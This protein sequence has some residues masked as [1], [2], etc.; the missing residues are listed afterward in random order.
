[1]TQDERWMANWKE[2][3]DFLRPCEDSSFLNIPSFVV[4][5]FL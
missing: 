2:V 5:I 1:M 4:V 3:M